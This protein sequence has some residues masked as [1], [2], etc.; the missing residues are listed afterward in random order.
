MQIW[1]GRR[2][3]DRGSGRGSMEAI[4]SSRRWVDIKNK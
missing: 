4:S 3:W 1:R 2:G